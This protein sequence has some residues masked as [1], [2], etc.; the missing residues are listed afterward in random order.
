MPNKYRNVKIKRTNGVT[1]DSVL[2]YKILLF[3]ENLQRKNVISNLICQNNFLLLEGFKKDYFNG[4]QNKVITRKHRDINYIAD[5]CFEY[6]NK[7]VVLEAKGMP[8][9]KYPIK[10]KLFLNKYKNEYIF[11]EITKVNQTYLIEKILDELIDKEEE[12]NVKD[13]KI[14]INK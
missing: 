10:R 13:E 3:L 12:R 11:L 7:R 8:D 4:K 1:V 5:F 2:E 9:E 14:K 6:K